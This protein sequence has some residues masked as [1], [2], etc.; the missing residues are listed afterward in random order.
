MYRDFFA[1]DFFSLPLIPQLSPP[2]L[3]LLLS[4]LPVF[5]SFPP[6]LSLCSSL[7]PDHVLL[8]QM[9]KQSIAADLPKNKYNQ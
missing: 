3:S 2:S 5:L 4:L 6:D 8:D 9:T 1:P 7:S